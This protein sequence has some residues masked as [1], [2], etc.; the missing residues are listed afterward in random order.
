MCTRYVKLVN[1]GNGEAELI[2]KVGTL[3]LNYHYHGYHCA[4]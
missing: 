4:V 2:I 3:I 1:S